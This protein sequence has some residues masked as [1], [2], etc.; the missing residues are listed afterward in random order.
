MKKDT[1]A[2]NALESEINTVLMKKGKVPVSK[3]PDFFVA[4]LGGADRS[5]V[6]S[7]LDKKG[8]DTIQKHPSA[9]IVLMLIDANT[10]SIIW[11]STAE[12]ETKSATVE[13]RK[14]RLDYTVKKMLKGI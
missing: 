9:A 3:N 2:S 13:E 11:M 10:G 7:K 5:H 4:Y 6:E 12:G 14:K 1:S 8:K